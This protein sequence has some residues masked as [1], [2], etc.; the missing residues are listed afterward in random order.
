MKAPKCRLCGVLHWGL[1]VANKPVA[2]KKD[3]ANIVANN[4]TT[5]DESCGDEIHN[6]SRRPIRGVVDGTSPLLLGEGIRDGALTAKTGHEG[7]GSRIRSAPTY[8]YRDA[9]KRRA[10]QREYMRRRRLN[11]RQD[12]A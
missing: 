9:E 6:E 1:C 10:Y 11:G 8:K 7:I 5:P 12:V 2:N 3:V 4:K